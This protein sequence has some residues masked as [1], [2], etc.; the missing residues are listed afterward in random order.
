MGTLSEILSN[1]PAVA[2]PKLLGC[3]LA[4]DGLS[5]VITEVEA[6]GG[7]GDDPASHAFGRRTSRNDVM[8]REPGLLYVYFTYGM[9]WCAN[10]VAHEPGLAGAI[11]IRG[12]RAVVGPARI[13]RTFGISGSDNGTDLLSPSSRIRLEPGR[14]KKAVLTSPRTGV[15]SAVQTPWRFYLEDEPVSPYRAGR[16]RQ[17]RSIRQDGAL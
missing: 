16:Q 4:T 9:H 11:L 7:Q 1:H 6:Y 8:F 17:Q 2:A 5:A 14:S 15:S 10:V 3:S 13:C 12:T